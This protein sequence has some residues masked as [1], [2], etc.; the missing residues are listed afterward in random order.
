MLG[1][2]QKNTGDYLRKYG[3][4]TGFRMVYEVDKMKDKLL[5]IDVCVLK[6][7]AI[8]MVVVAHY[9]RFFSPTSHLGGLKSIGFFGAALFAFLSGYLADINNEKVFRGGG[10]FIKLAQYIYH[11]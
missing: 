1:G 8:L 6:I 2:F 7:I 5:Y 9:Y 3:E 4:M 11:T 10:C